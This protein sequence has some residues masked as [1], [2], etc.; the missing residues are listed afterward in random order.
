MIEFI[1]NHK[2]KF[3]IGIFACIIAGWILFK[4]VKSEKESC[5]ALGGTLVYSETDSKFY[6]KMPSKNKPKPWYE[7]FFGI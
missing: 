2:Y 1:T 7:D 6:C 3:M 5:E 4:E